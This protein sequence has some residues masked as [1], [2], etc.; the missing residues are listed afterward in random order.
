MERVKVHESPNVRIILM[1][2]T[3]DTTTFSSYFNNAPVIEVSGRT[4]PVNQYFL[5]DTVQLLNFRPSEEAIYKAGKRRKNRKTKDE[6]NGQDDDGQDRLIAGKNDKNCNLEVSQEYNQNTRDV[7][8]L[9]SEE[10]IDYD[11]MG[12]LLGYIKSLGME[13]SVLVF[14]PGWNTIH[15]L[16]KYLKNSP[17][18]GNDRE[19]LVLPLHSQIPREE[20]FRVFY[21]AK[22]G[23]TK[24]ILSTNIAETSITID[25]VVFVIDSCKGMFTTLL[26]EMFS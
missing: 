18:Y 20:Q 26:L 2:A 19:Y 25:D 8:A 7:V 11:L 23:V 6:D 5:E 13:G 4:F 16:M 21:P 9:L 10:V 12:S 14:L 1:S 22:L 24:I 15:G 17:I 3:I